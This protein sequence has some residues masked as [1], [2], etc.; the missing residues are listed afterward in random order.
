MDESINNTQQPTID[1]LMTRIDK[2]EQ[3]LEYTHYM[4]AVIQ[5]SIQDN[6]KLEL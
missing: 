6:E 5:K 3:Q 2:L 1:E 4:L